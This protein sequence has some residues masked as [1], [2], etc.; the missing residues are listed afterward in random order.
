MSLLVLILVA[1]AP[2]DGFE[3]PVETLQRALRASRSATA[4]VEFVL[5]D[6]RTANAHPHLYTWRA[7]GDDYALDDHGDDAGVVRRGPTGEPVPFGANDAARYLVKHAEVW[8]HDEST[9]TARVYPEAD[10]FWPVIDLRT[11]ASNPGTPFEPDV[12]E[13]AR[14]ANRGLRYSIANEG[15][16][17]VVTAEVLDKD[18]LE[19]RFEWWIDPAKGGCVVKTA[20]YVGSR[21]IGETTFDLV[22]WDGVWFPQRIELRGTGDEPGVRWSLDVI[23]AEFNRPEHPKELTPNDIGVEVGMIV[24]LNGEGGIPRGNKRWDGQKL[25]DFEDVFWRVQAGEL[26]LGPTMIRWQ[27]EGSAAQAANPAAATGLQGALDAAARPG[28]RNFETLWEAYTRRFIYH[29]GL[30]VD[31]SRRAWRICSES[32]RDARRYVAQNRADFDRLA[33]DQPDDNKTDKLMEPIRTIFNRQLRDGLEK[34][35]TDAQRAAAASRA[36]PNAGAPAKSEKP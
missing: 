25:A 17:R 5:R 33:S 2:R 34:L 22:E 27:N 14:G 23:A 10:R 29:Y 6:D 9:P 4:K 32:Q 15:A 19:G 11:I 31:Q 36:P 3:E 28:P 8:W 7:A 21:Q 35:P 12:D 24:L 16:F 20:T 30:E 1:M 18:N 26:V 13:V